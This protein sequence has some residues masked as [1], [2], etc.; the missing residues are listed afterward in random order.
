MLAVAPDSGA[1]LNNLAVILWRQNQ[2]MGALQDYDRGIQAWPVRKAILD[3]VAE[4]LAAVPADQQKNPITQKLQRRF[5]EQDA[6]LQMLMAQNG[7][8]RWGATWVDQETLEKLK[9]AEKSMND[10]LARIN[11]DGT[12]AQT[13]ITE[14]DRLTSTNNATMTQLQSSAFSRDAEGHVV[15]LPLPPAFYTLQNENERMASE[16]ATLQTKIQTLTAEAKKAPPV[17]ARSAVHRSAANDRPRRYAR[18][19]DDPACALEE[20][21]CFDSRIR[22]RPLFGN[23]THG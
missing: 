8:Y 4:A 22:D 21:G 5:A 11:T 23:S 15:Q 12:A 14:I 6:Q 9:A 19:S 3:N 17:I 1:G 2:P 13:R 16:R 7:Q 18:G 20:W 10:T